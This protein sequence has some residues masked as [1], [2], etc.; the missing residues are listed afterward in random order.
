M[1]IVKFEPNWLLFT[2]PSLSSSGYSLEYFGYS[3]CKLFTSNKF[4]LKI[5]FGSLPRV[6]IFNRQF[7]QTKRSIC[8]LS[9]ALPIHC[10]LWSLSIECG[11]V[12]KI[13]RRSPIS[14]NTS[15][16]IVFVLWPSPNQA[17]IKYSVRSRTNHQITFAYLMQTHV[18]CV[19]ALR[20]KI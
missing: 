10:S 12:N 5:W 14:F 1:N 19:W 13:S 15:V 8:K 7:G 6:L 9:L 2:L 3:S 16:F 17:P 11:V 4:H 20:S 18:F